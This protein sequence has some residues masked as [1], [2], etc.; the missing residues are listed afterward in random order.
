MGKLKLLSRTTQ[1]LN[2]YRFE[3]DNQIV[4]TKHYVDGEGRL[5]ELNVFTPRGMRVSDEIRRMVKR[6]IEA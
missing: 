2:Y 1:T 4:H 5:I 6:Q 3:V